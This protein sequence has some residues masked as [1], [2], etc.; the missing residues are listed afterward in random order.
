MEIAPPADGT[1]LRFQ[2]DR[3]L[4]A[5]DGVGSGDQFSELQAGTAKGSGSVV[6][7]AEEMTHLTLKVIS[8]TMFSSDGGMLGEL[9]D[10]LDDGAAMTW[11]RSTSA[12]PTSC[13]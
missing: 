13:R 8:E 6:D 4:R 7:V 5:G 11:V 2:I 3:L 1:E 9:I 10:R 12:S